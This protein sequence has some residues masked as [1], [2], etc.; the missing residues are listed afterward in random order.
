MKRLILF[1][2]LTVTMLSGCS[3]DQ[4]QVLQTGRSINL[5]PTEKETRGGY[6]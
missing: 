1:F 4:E 5:M 2:L 3:N 6:N